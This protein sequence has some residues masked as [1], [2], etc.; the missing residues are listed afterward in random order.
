MVGLRNSGAVSR[1][2]SVPELARLLFLVRG[3]SEINEILLETERRRGDLP[4]GFRSEDHPV[5]TPPEHVTE[6]DVVVRRSVGALGHEQDGQLVHHALWLA[7]R[8]AYRQAPATVAVTGCHIQTALGSTRR[9]HSRRTARAAQHRTTVSVGRGL[10]QS[11]EAA[12]W[13]RQGI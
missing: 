13:G 3:R 6:P 12:S 8:S 5:S 2:K 11:T 7:K 1:M 4:A 10:N 9:H